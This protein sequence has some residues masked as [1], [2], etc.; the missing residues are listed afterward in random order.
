MASLQFLNLF[1][2]F[3]INGGLYAVT[4][5]C[6]YQVSGGQHTV[7]DFVLIGTY[8][9]QLMTPLNFLGTVYRVIQESFINME[10]MF[11]LLEEEVEVQ[12]KPG[13]LPFFQ[14]SVPPEIEFRRVS[15]HYCE[16]KPVLEDVSFVIESG[17]STAVVGATGCGKSTLAKILFRLFDP[18]EGG[19]F[20]NKVNI[21]EYSQHSYRS[22]VGVVPQDTVLFNDTIR[23][24][25]A[26]GRI[27]AGQQEVEE[28]AKMAEIH[29]AILG[30]PDGYDTVVGERGLKLSGGEK[31]RIAIARTLLKNPNIVI[32]DEATS[33]LD[34]ETERNI[35]V[36]ILKWSL[37]CLV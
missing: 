14:C 26:Y 34:T 27:E 18:V 24:N 33:S 20:I 19:V 28:A 13:A 30:F 2:I 31:Q 37:S 29:E 25:I 6:A 22:T 8:F 4:M 1:Q 10:N 11:T 7:G 12:D 16:A 9:L 23:Y 35:Q 17:T 5:Y 21:K 32:F 15:F 3:V 36:N